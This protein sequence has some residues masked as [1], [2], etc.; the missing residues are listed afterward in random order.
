MKRDKKNDNKND[1]KNTDITTDINDAGKNPD[2]HF[3]SLRNR[4]LIAMPNM[5]DPNFSKVVIFICE[6]TV[7]GALGIIINQPV[8]IT[9]DEVLEHMKL[10][11]EDERI[12]NLPVLF[13]G[14]VQQERGFIIHSPVGEWRASL[15]VNEE[16]AVTASRDILEAVAAGS[17]PKKI[18]TCLGY[19]GWGA[20]Q[21]EEEI[22][23]NMWLDGPVNSNIIFDMPFERRWEEAAK[24]IGID[25]RFFSGE[26]GHA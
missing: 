13:G 25:T 7:E 14:P 16:I 20:G 8:S 23:K 21:L 3:E 1:K 12:N 10:K 22:A 19:A 24:L 2:G 4:C 18:L 11:S 9:F 5:L 17:G 26:A 15:S 6:H